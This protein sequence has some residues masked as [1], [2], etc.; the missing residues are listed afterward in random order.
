[1]DTDERVS[2]ETP[3]EG[4]ECMPVSNGEGSV[5]SKGTDVGVELAGIVNTLSLMTKRT[6]FVGVA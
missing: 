2:N 5:V 4:A 6:A 1:M 3:V